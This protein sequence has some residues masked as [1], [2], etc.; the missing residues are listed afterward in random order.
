MDHSD[1]I[2]E[3]KIWNGAA[4]AKH[5]LYAQDILANGSISADLMSADVF[6]GRTFIGGTYKT[7]NG[8]L[9]MN[10]AGLALFDSSGNRTVSMLADTGDVVLR[11]LHMYGGV[12]DAPTINA[13]SIVGADYKL[14]VDGVT[15]AQMNASGVYFGDHAEKDKKA[16][17]LAKDDKDQWVLSIRGAIQSDS[18]I[19]GGT[20]TGATVQTTA[21]KNRGLKMTTGGLVA[22]SAKNQPTFTLIADTGDILMDGS[23][24]SNVTIKSAR[25][26][27]GE[28][29]GATFATSSDADNRVSLDST[30]LHVVRDGQTLID[31]NLTSGVDVGES[32]LAT[33]SELTATQSDLTFAINTVRDEAADDV[34]AVEDALNT[35][36]LERQTYMRFSNVDNNPLLEL[37]ATDSEYRVQLSNT[38]LSFMAGNTEA[39]YVANDGMNI[40]NATILSTLTIGNF[41]WVPRENGHLSLQYMGGAA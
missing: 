25:V 11:N 4:W 16:F 19:S 24:A 27:A 40:A 34:Q 39:A 30:G 1:E 17:A 3:M 33:S 23:L 37:G 38:K 9:I 32:G 5:V 8:N 29:V 21:D 36:I 6:N 7:T 22:Y 12:Q 28:I 13:G 18:D 41:A 15:F 31:F 20:V 35:D 2:E 14:A 26:E 10:D